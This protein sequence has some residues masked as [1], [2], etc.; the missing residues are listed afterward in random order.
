MAIVWLGL[1]GVAV[2][3]MLYFYLIH[4]VGPTRTSLVTYIFPLVGV[5]LGVLFLKETLDWH[6]ALGTVFI[7]GSL[8][9]VN[10]K[11]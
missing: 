5:V 8:I 4:S 1:M 2:A 3:Y 7:V 9:L 10:R 6:L 11:A